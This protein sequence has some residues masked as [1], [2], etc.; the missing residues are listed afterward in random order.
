[1]TTTDTCPC[2]PHYRASTAYRRGCRHPATRHAVNRHEKRRVHGLTPTPD[3]DS[4]GTSRRLQ[5]LA[6]TGWPAH[7][8]TT[9]TGLAAG[10]LGQLRYGRRHRVRRDTAT[11]IATVYDQ[12]WDTPGPSRHMR[13]RANHFGWQPPLAWSDD[14][15]DN[16]DARPDT[17][18]P[19]HG[20]DLTEVEHLRRYGLNDTHIADRLGIKVE[21]IQQAIRRRRHHDD[22][23]A[24]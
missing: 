12:L 7:A 24:A 3:I 14:T 21:S 23:T 6:A 10:H 19:E 1:M 17:G 11:L 20:L 5:A 15:I 2:H 4:T 9:H 8:L 13:E 16:P 22:R 18:R